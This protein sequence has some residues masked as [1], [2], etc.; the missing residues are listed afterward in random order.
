M[1]ELSQALESLQATLKER[2]WGN[3]TSPMP[4]LG[5]I[6]DVGKPN[7][8]M[9]APISTSRAASQAKSS[10]PPMPTPPSSPSG[11]QKLIRDC[12]ESQNQLTILLAQAHL[13]LKG[14]GEKAEDAASRDAGFQWLLGRFTIDQVRAAFR[15]YIE[16]NADL[17]VPANIINLIEPPPQKLSA[18]VYIAYQKKACGGGWLLSDERQFCRDYEAQEMEA[19]RASRELLECH[20]AIEASKQKTLDIGYEGQLD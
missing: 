9:V 16:R 18:A 8:P 19:G 17:P 13:L 6:S 11:T 1:D 14:Y 5:S 15:T 10:E 12:N 4:P 7:T 2:G 20:R 3:D